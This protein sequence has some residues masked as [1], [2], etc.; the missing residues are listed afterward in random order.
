MPAINFQKTSGVVIVTQTSGAGKY[1][2]TNSVVKFSPN[3]AGNGVDINISGDPYMISLTDLT[4]NGQ[5]PANIGSALV[6]LN[7]LFGT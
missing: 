7:G 6:M 1:Y 5:V 4:I 3:T 2:G